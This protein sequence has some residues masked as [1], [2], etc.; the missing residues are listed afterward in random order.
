MPALTRPWRLTARRPSGRHGATSHCWQGRRGEC[1]RQQMTSGIDSPQELGPFCTSVGHERLPAAAVGVF[2]DGD[3]AYPSVSYCAS[4]AHALIE[5]GEFTVTRVLNP[6]ALGSISCPECG[7]TGRVSRGSGEQVPGADTPPAQDAEEL[8]PPG[9]LGTLLHFCT[10]MLS[11]LLCW[12]WV[13]V[14]WASRCWCWSAT[15]PSV[16]SWGGPRGSSPR[17]GGWSAPRRER[18][19]GD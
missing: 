9:L 5:C 3:E 15:M 6:L 2:D 13:A 4:C 18:Q 10:V 12:P 19:A 14:R 16:V 7:G 8:R 17:A 1:E 11:W